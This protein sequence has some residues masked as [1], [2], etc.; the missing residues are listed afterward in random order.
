MIFVTKGERKKANIRVTLGEARSQALKSKI[1]LRN[2]EKK[3]HL[4]CIGTEGCKT[5]GET[6]E[7]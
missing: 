7:E 5:S 1:A 3:R 4:D 6:I 2:G